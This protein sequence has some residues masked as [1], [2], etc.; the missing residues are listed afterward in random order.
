MANHSLVV[1]D[2]CIGL[3]PTVRSCLLQR[4]SFLE[5][6]H[7][8]NLSCHQHHAIE[9]ERWSPLL[10]D[11]DAFTIKIIMTRWRHMNLDT[12][13]KHDL[14]VAPD[15][16]M[17]H[18]WHVTPTDTAKNSFEPTVMIGVSVGE[19]DSAQVVHVSIKHIHIVEDRVA[20]KSCIVEHGLGATVSLHREHQRISMLSNQLLAF[21]PFP[22]ER[23]SPHYLGAGQEEIDEIIHQ[24]RNIRYIDW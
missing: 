22:D 13:R 20:S 24:Y 17:Q 11:C 2:P 4:K 21:R 1:P 9:Q 23:C 7:A 6:G 14:A 12:G 18:E 3:P 5:V 15:I 10:N 16:R 19:N 8:I